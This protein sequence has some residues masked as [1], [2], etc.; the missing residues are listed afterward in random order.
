MNALEDSRVS[1]DFFLQLCSG[2]A[3]NIDP[4]KPLSPADED[5]DV[6]VKDPIFFWEKL[7]VK[8]LAIKCDVRFC[9]HFFFHFQHLFPFQPDDVVMVSLEVREESEYNTDKELTTISS[10]P[11]LSN[12]LRATG[13]LLKLK[14]RFHFAFCFVFSMFSE[15]E[16]FLSDMFGV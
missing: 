13:L 9:F 4:P 1:D 6:T 16:Q 14:T 3:T 7:A 8:T 5:I 2:E 10:V 11:L 15:N 12:N